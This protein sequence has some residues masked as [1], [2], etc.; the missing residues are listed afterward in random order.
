MRKCWSGAVR[1]V[2]SAGAP[3]FLAAALQPGMRAMAVQ[4]SVENTAGGFILPGDRVD[5][6][7]SRR[8]KNPDHVG[9][10]IIVTE[11]LLANVRVLA[12]DQAPKEKEGSNSLVGKTVTLELKPVSLSDILVGMTAHVTAFLDGGVLTAIQVTVQDDKVKGTATPPPATATNT[13]S[14]TSTSTPANTP[15][16]TSTPTVTP[17]PM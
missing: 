6:I 8:D 12:I 2:I 3:D 16:P 15:T 14:P 11:I 13:P 7:L 17:T 9:P 4:V 1:E 5:V 10:D